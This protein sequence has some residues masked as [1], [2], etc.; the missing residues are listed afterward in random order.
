MKKIFVLMAAVLLLGA[1]A[2][3]PRYTISGTVPKGKYNGE[4]I[5]LVPFDKPNA[6][7]VDSTIIQNDAF[8]FQ[9]DTERVAIIR[10]PIRL[11][12]GMEELLVV[13]EPGTTHVHI[14]SV[15]HVSGTPQNEALQQWK[16][17]MEQQQHVARVLMKA[18]MKNDT[19]RQTAA[20]LMLDSLR[21]QSKQ[22][23][24]QISKRFPHSTLVQFFQKLGN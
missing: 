6:S 19:K 24:E 12:L 17:L 5:Y 3:A 2:K 23:Q 9:G 21:T 8:E 20:Q 18:E 11:R 14:D 22:M 1:C 15:S 4:K 10:M 16:N 7:N 13:T